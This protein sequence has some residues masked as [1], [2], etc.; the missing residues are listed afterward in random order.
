MRDG[1][2]F[3]RRHGERFTTAASTTAR[4]RPMTDATTCAPL[5]PEIAEAIDALPIDVGALFSGLSDDS[6][7]T[8]RTAMAKM[9]VAELSANV[10]RTDHEIP[11]SDGVVVRVHRPIGATD[12]LPCLYWMHGGGLVLGSYTGDDARFD[13]WSPM[14]GLVGVSVEYRLAPETRYPGPLEDCYAGLRWVHEYA[15]ELGVDRDR[16]G[17]GGSSAGGNLAAGLGILARDRGEIPLAYQLLICPMLDDRQITASSRWP[18]PIWPPSANTYGWTAYLGDRRGGPDVTAYAAPSRATDLAGLPPTLPVSARR[19]R[20]LFRRRHR[21]CAGCG[22]AMPAFRWTYSFMQGHR[23]D[24]PRWRP[25][26]LSLAAPIA[27]SK[28][29]S[30][31]GLTDSRRPGER[32]ERDIASAAPE[33]G[34]NASL[35]STSAPDTYCVDRPPRRL[36]VAALVGLGR[37]DLQLAVG[38]RRA[39][40]PTSCPGLTREDLRRASPGRATR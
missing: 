39:A 18:D 22:C 25:G 31:P 21:V 2:G 28:N 14:F 40:P 37:H 19:D 6:I 17:I 33:T 27:M 13:R 34:P 29:G 35:R 9:N 8:A 15:A 36:L 16:I 38:L 11:G 12:G 3:Y 10:E 24:S 5:D 30:A 23:T 32:R 7:S 1:A 26:R 20:R 4:M